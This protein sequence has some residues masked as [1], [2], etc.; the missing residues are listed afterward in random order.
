MFR[1]GIIQYLGS[2]P[3]G[4]FGGGYAGSGNT[5]YTDKYTYSTDAVSAGT[6]LRQARYY[7]AACSSTA[8][9]LS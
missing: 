2:N 1:I 7:L 6:V 4:L 5:A 3:F 9:G 8:N